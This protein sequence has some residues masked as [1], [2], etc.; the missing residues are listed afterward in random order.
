V[1]RHGLPLFLTAEG[2][3]VNAQSTSASTSTP[4][5]LLPIL[6]GGGIAGILDLT[7]AFI[8][9]GWK[10]PRGIA[11]GLLG[12]RA[13][14]GSSS[15]LLFT[16][17]LGVILHFTIAFGAATIYCLTARRLTFLE[18]NFLVC[19]LFYGIAVY[20]VMNLIVLPLSAFPIKTG[21]FTLNGL[22]EG[23]LIHMILIGLPI[24]FGAW[25]FSK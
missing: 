1:R 15:W 16:W 13:F 25:R 12:T 5:L 18:E 14:Q 3:T 22:R 17:I 19:G 9:F 20:L 6:I 21:T 11:M 10:V 24:S 23:I 2:H 8:T 7:S 4:K